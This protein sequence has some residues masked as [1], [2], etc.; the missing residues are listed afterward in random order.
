ME[1]IDSLYY[2]LIKFLNFFSKTTQSTF[3]VL[4]KAHIMHELDEYYGCINVGLHLM[5]YF[6]V[7]YTADDFLD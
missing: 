4:L 1:I 2:D 7:H 3:K 6:I 5:V